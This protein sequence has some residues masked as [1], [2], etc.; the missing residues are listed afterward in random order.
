M[1]ES[2]IIITIIFALLLTALETIGQSSLH[3]FFNQN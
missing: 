3:K 2:N 1:K